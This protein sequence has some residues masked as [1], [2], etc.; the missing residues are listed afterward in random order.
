MSTQPAPQFSSAIGE[1]AKKRRLADRGIFLEKGAVSTSAGVG[2]TTAVS[3][4][5]PWNLPPV[6][7]VEAL[8]GSES[9]ATGSIAVNGITTTGFNI[10][11]V[12]NPGAQT[13]RWFAV[14]MPNQDL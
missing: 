11:N 14:R 4:A 9:N 3:F 6:V 7:F 12:N 13:V 5:E 1:F 10:Y 8:S 2:N